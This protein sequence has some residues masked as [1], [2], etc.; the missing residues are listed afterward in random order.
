MEIKQNKNKI[1]W[2]KQRLKREKKTYQKSIINIFKRIKKL[3]S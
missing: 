1:T 2:R 3:E